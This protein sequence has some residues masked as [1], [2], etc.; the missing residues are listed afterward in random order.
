M[1]P[2]FPRIEWPWLF[3]NVTGTMK[4]RDRG[5][6]PITQWHFR[7]YFQFKWYMMIAVTIFPLVF[8]NQTVFRLFFQN[9]KWKL[10]FFPFPSFGR[11]REL[12]STIVLPVCS[13]CLSPRFLKDGV[14]IFGV[15]FSLFLDSDGKGKNYVL[16]YIYIYNPSFG[17]KRESISMG[18]QFMS[19][20]EI[21]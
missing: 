18:L 4:G 16:I 12:I 19:V 10:S 17:K 15:N 1:I 2:V 20:A 11:K 21:L 13:S 8:W 5:H 7:V 14:Q 6:T 3:T 9:I